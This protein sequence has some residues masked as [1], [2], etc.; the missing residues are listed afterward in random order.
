MLK[1]NFRQMKITCNAGKYGGRALMA[2]SLCLTFSS[3]SLGFSS[4]VVLPFSP[5]G[6]GENECDLLLLLDLECD[7]KGILHYDP[8]ADIFIFCLM[9]D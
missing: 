1:I 4:S 8:I 5:G 3:S 2:S 6:G 7:L 9:Q